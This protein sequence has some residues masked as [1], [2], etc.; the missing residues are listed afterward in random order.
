MTACS[1]S[2]VAPTNQKER[3][4]ADRRVPAEAHAAAH[5]ERLQISTTLGMRGLRKR[6]KMRDASLAGRIAMLGLPLLLTPLRAL[7][8]G[9]ACALLL[10]AMPVPSQVPGAAAELAQPAKAQKKAAAAKPLA[11]PPLDGKSCGEARSLLLKYHLA[12]SGCKPGVATGRVA[13]GL[14]NGQTPLAGTPLPQTDGVVS[15][16]TEPAP[17][18]LTV[19]PVRVPP[20]ADQPVPQA[21][22]T[23]AVAGLQAGITPGENDDS[24]YVLRG[25]PPSGALV[26]RGSTVQLTTEVRV[27][28][29]EV[30]GRSAADARALIEKG[31]L[32]SVLEGPKAEEGVIARDSRPP[33][34]TLVALG[35]MVQVPLQLTVPELEHLSCEEARARA[36]LFGFDELQCH[37]Q[38]QPEATPDRVFSQKPLPNTR[39]EAP[40]VLQVALPL[41]LVTVPDLRDRSPDAAR[42]AL[43]ALKLKARFD[44]AEA[45]QPGR[46]VDSQSPAAGERVDEGTQVRLRTLA[47]VPVP[48]VSGLSC[49]AMSAEAE[50]LGL[51][52]SCDITSQVVTFSEPRVV[53]QRVA[54]GTLVRPGTV[55]VA[56]L[57]ASTP[58]GW[59]V[60]AAALAGAAG[61]AW[62]RWRQPRPQEM[63]LHTEPLIGLRAQPDPVPE[64]Q[65]HWTDAAPQPPALT[66]RAEPGI[67][68]LSVAGLSTLGVNDGQH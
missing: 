22:N 47:L 64:L 28:V 48:D 35:T 59:I 38:H 15:A 50:R 3:F 45:A 5:R 41:V 10:V 24:H 54:P 65:L 4:A 33:G 19:K 61:L 23:L 51:L 57:R 46:V 8:A 62:M 29:P 2:D 34:G 30:A 18:K 9:L 63:Q 26:P 32:H 21:R 7:S 11:V 39:L 56:T 27:R 17:T 42:A 20:L 52:P 44:D 40:V 13:E 37:R 49:A 1:K 36:R 66:L 55:L 60:L 14:I 67:A 31:G 58:W 12:L 6:R 68:E 53:A 43:D 16:T 25:D